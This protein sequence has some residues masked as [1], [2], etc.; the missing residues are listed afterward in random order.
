MVERQPIPM[1]IYNLFIYYEEP[2]DGA[3]HWIY[4]ELGVL[5][6]EEDYTY[7]GEGRILHCHS[8]ETRENEGVTIIDREYSF[9]GNHSFVMTYTEVWPDG[10]Y[11]PEQLEEQFYD[12]Y[13]SEIYQ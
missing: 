5:L 2:H 12:A 6:R 13:G 11:D 9:T 7:D 3:T 10:V 8:V 4:T 1:V